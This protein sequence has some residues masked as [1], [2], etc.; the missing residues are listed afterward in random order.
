MADKL[1]FS[2]IYFKPS[3][4]YYTTEEVEVDAPLEDITFPNGDASAL[5]G[6]RE[7]VASA[8]HAAHPSLV[9][10][11]DDERL[12]FPLMVTAEA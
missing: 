12:W 3:G 10:M 11:V 8:A 9:A 2:V 6:L 7:R 5:S 4:K 1:R